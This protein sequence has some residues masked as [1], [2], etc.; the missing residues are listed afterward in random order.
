MVHPTSPTLTMRK[1]IQS[2]LYNNK[3]ITKVNKLIAL[4]LTASLEENGVWCNSVNKTFQLCPTTV[5]H[6]Y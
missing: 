5:L 6:Q 3:Q 1:P 4:V 2:R